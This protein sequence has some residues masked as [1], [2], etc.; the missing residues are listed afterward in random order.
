MHTR[1]RPELLILPCDIYT[2]DV[3]SLLLYHMCIGMMETPVAQL[4]HP[5]RESRLLREADPIFIRNLKE[6]MMKDP[7]A[8]GAT[9]MA[10][11]CKD[12]DSLDT[13]NVKYKNVY[14]NYEVI[15]GLHTLMA[16]SQLKDEF[17]K[18]PFFKTAL[19][20]VYVSLSDEGCLRLAQRHNSNS[21]FIHRV[22]HRD[23]VSSSNLRIINYVNHSV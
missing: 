16:K 11:L 20:E 23:L 5:P 14:N 12:A 7:S 1:G 22:T 10:V 2:K 8:P 9:P 15:G 3:F 18:N 6:K 4:M 13:F 19:A 17:P 21:H